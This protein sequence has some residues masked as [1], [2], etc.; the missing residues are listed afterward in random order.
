MYSIFGFVF[1]LGSLKDATYGSVCRVRN[2][3][4]FSPAGFA[5]FARCVHTHT[6][7]TNPPANKTKSKDKK[8]DGVD[9]DLFTQT[10][11]A[12][13]ST[14]AQ[15]KEVL[16]DISRALRSATTEG[17]KSLINKSEDTTFKGEC[18]PT[19]LIYTFMYSFRFLQTSANN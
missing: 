14:K 8:P 7:D 3:H 19:M 4:Q 11:P 10:D 2:V 9:N 18:L 15:V 12:P 1:I 16:N 5:S 17:A 13:V 6:Q